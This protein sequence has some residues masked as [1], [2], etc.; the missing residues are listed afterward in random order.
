MRTSLA[1]LVLL[2]V[3]G[4]A[5][6]ADRD[7]PVGK[8]VHK[9]SKA[10][11]RPWSL[12]VPPKYSPRSSW[13]LVVSSHGRDGTGKG[14][15]GQWVPLA[16]EHGFLVACPDMCSAT[17]NRP[18][19]S[20][21]PAAV[22][23]EQ[24]LLSI[25]EEVKERFRINPRAV[26]VTGFSGGGNPSYWTGLRH[27]DVFT[28]I[29]TRGGNFS[30]PQVPRD[31]KTLRAGRSRLR[32]LIYYGEM[33]HPLIVGEGGKPGQ[34]RQAHDA[35][36]KAGYEHV[37]IRE[38]PGMKHRSRPDIAADWFG[39]WLAKNKRRFADGDRADALLAGARAAHEK[40]KIR[41]AIRKLRDLEKL[42]AKSGLHPRAPGE[43]ERID[44]DGR[45][46]I[47]AARAARDR[48]ETKE[49][50]REVERLARDYRGLPSGEE[51]RRLKSTWSGDR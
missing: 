23:D 13:P 7:W 21:L 31:E 43:L 28:H 5:A 19:R 50:L 30:P 36:V 10:H 24:V 45:E 11:G 6:A 12:Y 9:T 48:G 34:A 27:P 20:E 44:A 42:E 22:E 3:A 51:A 38:I 25:V 37:E 41:E 14:E 46:R 1:V 35:L 33:D 40:G 17:V 49:A 2:L 4:T 16:R 8:V 29:C 39:A 32:V 15:M 26:M 18:P 47:A